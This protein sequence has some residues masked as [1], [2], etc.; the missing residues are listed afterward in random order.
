MLVIVFHPMWNQFL[1][2]FKL[3]HKPSALTS[4]S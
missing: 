4:T 1:Q 2:Y 3:I